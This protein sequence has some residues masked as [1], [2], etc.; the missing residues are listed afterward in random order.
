MAGKMDEL[1]DAL[2]HPIFFL[3]VVSLGV[4]S[5]L[6]LMS[7]GAKAA[8]LPGVSMLLQHP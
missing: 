7:W 2:D 3:F 5:M 8:G 6:A 1:A 4:V